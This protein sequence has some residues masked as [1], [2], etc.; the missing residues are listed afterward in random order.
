LKQ[1][2]GVTAVTD[3]GP[4]G[5][6][7]EMDIE[8]ATDLREEVGALSAQRGWALRELSWRRPTLEE[9]FARIALSLGE[10]PAAKADD[11]AR[12]R[13]PGAPPVEA[14][15]L[16]IAGVPIAS[17]SEAPSA[18]PLAPAAPKKIV[19]NLNPFDMGASRDLGRPKAVDSAAPVALDPGS[20]AGEE[21]AAGGEKRAAD[22]ADT[23]AKRE[24]PPGAREPK[25]KPKPG[26]GADEPRA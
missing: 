4:R 23:A 14:R 21:R 10:D 11:G 16:D 26:A 19:Y 6:N 5:I 25:P 1:I 8:C 13:G 3:H 12:D 24:P 20:A 18:T 17:A 22:C 9:I 7:S 15:G 2:S